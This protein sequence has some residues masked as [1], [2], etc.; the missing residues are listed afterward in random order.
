MPPMLTPATLSMGIPCSIRALMT[1]MCAQPLAPPPP[2]TRVKSVPV[3]CRAVEVVNR[4]LL[5][6]FHNDQ[7]IRY[8]IKVVLLK[9]RF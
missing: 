1:P 8:C 2:R 5:F 7:E 9:I 6:Y 3:K 4:S